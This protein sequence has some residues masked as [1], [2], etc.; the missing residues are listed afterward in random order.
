MTIVAYILGAI[1]V[2]IAIVLIVAM[3]VRKNYVIR[4]QIIID[5]P[6][7]QVFD[8][9]KFTQN[10]MQYNKWFMTDPNHRKE[11]R[12]TDGTAGFV[13]AWDSDMKQAGKGEQETKAVADGARLDYEI[14]F[15]KPFE[16]KADVAM[17]T[18]AVT[19]ISTRVDWS[20][21]SGMKYPMN[22]M[23][24]F[25]DFEK[26]LGKDMEESLQNLKAQLEKN[27]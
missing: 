11:L 5:K 15:I 7:Q 2:L 10:A 13:Y 23:L 26:M 12:G 16:G 9:V 1:I 8:Y 6:K 22:I 24:L 4:R 25:M 21:S 17:T 3:F 14:R 27:P 19:D 18:D 20:F